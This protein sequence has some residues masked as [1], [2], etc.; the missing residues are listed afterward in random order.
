MEGA[1]DEVLEAFDRRTIKKYLAK[2]SKPSQ[3]D[4]VS[5]LSKSDSSRVDSMFLN[6]TIS[7]LTITH[8]LSLRTV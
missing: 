3:T 2:E 4:R 1:V 8:R 5:L 7:P 6:L